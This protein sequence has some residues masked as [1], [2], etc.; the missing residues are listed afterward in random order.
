M[1]RLKRIWRTSAL[2]AVLFFVTHPVSAQ[3]YTQGADPGGLRWSSV[4]TPTY[5]VIY[6]RGLDSLARAYAVTLERVATPVGGSIGFRPN[7]AYRSKMPVVLH[8]WTAQSNGQVTWTPRR[9]ELLTVT[10]AFSADPTPWVLQ[11]AV[12]ESRH[13]AQMQPGASAP[14]RW[15]RVLGGELAAGGL[16][17]VYGGPAFLEGDAVVAETALTQAGRGRTADFLEYYRVSFAAG[18]FRDYWRWR[19]GSQR[20]YTP[21]YYRA[22]YL[23]IGGIRALYGV[24]DLTERFY[25]RIAD[26]GGVAFLNW[27][28][29]VRE[30]T[31]KPFRQ[32]FAEVCDSLQAFWA[33]D[34]AARGPF[35]PSESVSATPRRFTE[36][37]NLTAAGNGLYAVRTGITRPARLV[38]LDAGG[39]DTPLTLLGASTSHPRFSG[40]T[41]RLY[42]S[43]VVPD[44]RWPLRSWSVVR[45]SD[46]QTSRPLTKKTRY[47]HPAPAPDRPVLAVTE[48]PADGS[49]RV[50]LLD[51]RD[52]SV[53]EVHPA[54]AGLQ[55]LE[56]AWAGGELYASGIDDAGAGIFRVADFSPVLSSKPVSIKQ[57]QGDAEGRLLFTSDHSGVNELYSLDPAGG[58]LLQLT[59]TRLGASDFEILRDTLFYSCLQPEGRLVRKTALSELAPRPAD[60]SALPRHPFAEELSAG[61]PLA[62]N[63]EAEVEVSEPKPYGKLAHLLHFHS[64][65]PLYLDYDAVDNLSLATLEQDAGL[66]ATAFWQNDLGTGFGSLGYHAGVSEGVWRHSAHAKVSYTGLYPVL[67]ASLDLGGREAL[68]YCVEETDGRKALKAG[69][70][71]NASVSGRLRAYIPWNFSSGG[72]LRGLVPSATLLFSNDRFESG[73]PMN[74]T[75]FSLRGY[76][77]QRTPPS[78]LYPRFGVGAEL[79][80][81][82]RW[83]PGLIAPSGYFS[84]YGYLPGLHETHGLRWSGL[85]SRRLGAGTFCEAHANL[86]PRGFTGAVNAHLAAYPVQFKASLDYKMPLLPVD[87][88]LL[89]P[90]SY[91]RNFELTLHGDRTAFS[92]SKESG[93]LLS[94]GADFAAVLGNLAWIPYPT[95]IGVSYS[96][97]GG[98]SFADLA[99]QGLVDGHHAVSLLFSIEL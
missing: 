8:P 45:I 90:V 63:P 52:G 74:R 19:Y 88:A 29:T 14:F 47:F 71:G 50:V 86:A 39:K 5:R 70:L 27:D 58:E 42:W 61:E 2:A 66:G 95:R 85:L 99:G 94:A 97:L 54:P 72:W 4:E 49:S 79:G 77:M 25:R 81:S 38:R 35:L 80:G 34:E 69:P 93:S 32:A 1:P 44:A 57:L 83:V 56:T 33:A 64:W 13:V 10:D 30:A 82:F 26:H 65:L 17:A 91:L 6:P 36:F 7:A 23:A 87:R 89:G 96:F 9:M 78:R 21:D 92:S 31:G 67:E 40:A 73:A 37:R 12:H 55:V 11:L 76:I 20:Y 43:E 84:L 98:V 60:W 16:S 62:V 3:F 24:P 53:L 46:G 41:G 22:G 68:G 75:T 48:Y 59:A 18:D 51:A 15:L 28:K